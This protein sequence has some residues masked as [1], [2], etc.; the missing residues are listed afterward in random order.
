MTKIEFYKSDTEIFYPCCEY[1]R[2]NTTYRKV[3]FG[4]KIKIM[5][6][7]IDEY[8]NERKIFGCDLQLYSS[9]EIEKDELADCLRYYKKITINQWNNIVDLC[10]RKI[11]SFY[12][13]N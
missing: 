12:E 9:F 2:C 3:I 4:D 6:I 10:N 11:S 5:S 8:R 7:V 13:L 1:V